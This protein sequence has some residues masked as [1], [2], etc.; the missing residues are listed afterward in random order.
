MTHIL[1]NLEH[2]DNSWYFCFCSILYA[3]DNEHTANCHKYECLI[4]D[5]HKLKCNKTECHMTSNMLYS[6]IQHLT[7]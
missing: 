3:I 7:M 5:N 4:V 6:V 2:I 1:L